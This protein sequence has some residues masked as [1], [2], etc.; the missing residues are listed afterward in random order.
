MKS[1]LFAL[2]QLAFIPS[3]IAA[4]FREDPALRGKVFGFVELFTY[5]GIWAIFFHRICYLLSACKIPLIPRVISQVSRFLTGIEIHPGAKIGRGFFI[6]H[7]MGVV[8]GETS[9]IGEN[10]LLYHQVT[11]GGTSLQAGKRHP[12]LGNNVLV[13]AG[14]KIFGPVTI[15]DNCQVG[16]GA[17]V[18]KDAPKD[19][20][21]VGNPGKIVKRNG[22]RIPP[23]SNVDQIHL[24]DPIEKRLQEIEKKLKKISQ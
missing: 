13:G 15:G 22:K 24:P 3:D 11:L 7:G 8:I 18:I 14:A 19:S 1:F 23:V 9:E 20:V 5:P 17:V 12:T 6:D 10:V 16:G 2:R 21:V 4:G